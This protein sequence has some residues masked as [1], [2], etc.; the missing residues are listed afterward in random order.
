M[1]NA[2]TEAVMRSCPGC[3]TKI[4]KSDGC[5]KMVCPVTRCKTKFCYVCR[6]KIDGY[7]HFCRTPHCQHKNC[8][9]CVLF[10]NDKELDRIARREAGQKEQAAIGAAAANICLL[11]PPVKPKAKKCKKRNRAQAGPV[12]VRPVQ[13]QAQAQ[14]RP[15]LGQAQAQAQDR[16]ALGQA[17]IQNRR[18]QGQV[19]VHRA[20]AQAQAQAH[21]V[22]AQ[23]QAQDRP[24]LGQ[25]QIQNHRVQGQG[26]VRR[27]Q[28]RAHPVQ[29]QAQPQPLDRP[30]QGQAH[31]VQGRVANPKLGFKLQ[32]RFFFKALIVG[33]LLIRIWFFALIVYEKMKTH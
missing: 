26:Q 33:Y 13:A 16:P 19:Q 12:Q 32:G 28:A 6:Q 3:Q 11:S 1:A 29:A 31:P 21:P 30:E 8:G 20:Q 2:M 23:A 10:T 24:A 7:E 15:A 27:A 25:A 17:Q 18:V 4:V 14:D 5:N 22:Q 9:K